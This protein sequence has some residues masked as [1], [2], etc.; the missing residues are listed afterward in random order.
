MAEVAQ[1]RW[2]SAFPT[3]IDEVLAV[4]ADGG[5]R[6]VVRTARD[7]APVIGTFTATATADELALLEDQHREVD[8][9]HPTT[10]PVLTAADAV[11]VRARTQ[12]LATATFYL[13][14]VPGGGLALQAVGAGDGAAE[15]QLEPG[16]VIVHVER[17]G[18]EVGWHELDRLETG[19][20][21]PEPKG[22]GGVGRAAEIAPG[23]YGTIALPGDGIIGP[24]EVA[25]EV[26]GRLRDLL[27]ER[28]Y[29]GFRVRTAA[30]AVPA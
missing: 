18:R 13:A 22:L 3:E 30:V 14:V 7:G 2:R 16:S 10:D 24:A 11:A 26:R 29:E 25:V 12:P 4:D 6:L 17:D 9:R 23:A 27:P 15:F 28:S 20:V 1:I 5:A 8:L 19:F 21:S